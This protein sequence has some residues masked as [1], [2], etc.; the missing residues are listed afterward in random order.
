MDQLVLGT[1]IVLSA[2]ARMA[3]RRARP[4]HTRDHPSEPDRHRGLSG[5]TQRALPETY[6]ADPDTNGSWLRAGGP[7][8][9]SACDCRFPHGNRQARDHAAAGDRADRPEDRGRAVTHALVRSGRS[10]A[11]TDRLPDCVLSDR[12]QYRFWPRQHQP[13]NRASGPRVCTQPLGVLLEDNCRMRCH[14]SS[15]E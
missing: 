3:S 7:G 10:V 6:L 8:R 5:S 4:C 11:R 14:I 15:T 9:Y 12:D 1:G 13:R 2:P